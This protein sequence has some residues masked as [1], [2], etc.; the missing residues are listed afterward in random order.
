MGR[1]ATADD[2]S[3]VLALA[4][5]LTRVLLPGKPDTVLPEL[6]ALLRR[7]ARAREKPRPGRRYLR[8]SFRPTR[9]WGPT[10]RRGA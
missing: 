9:R 8:V 2:R 6:H 10:G 7:I 3:T 4:V 5:Y 1:V